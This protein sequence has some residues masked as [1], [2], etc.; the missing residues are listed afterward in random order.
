MAEPGI[1]QN[2]LQNYAL[3]D[4]SEGAAW[5]SSGILPS[6]IYNSSE[7]VK[8]DIR[9]YQMTKQA[10]EFNSSEAA[11]NRDFQQRMSNTSFQRAA[12]DLK[13]AGYS[14]LA[15]LG[16]G[17]ASSPSGSVASSSSPGSRG[18]GHDS[19]SG[20]IVGSL[21]AAFGSLLTKG[22]T[23]AIKAASVS[24][25]AAAAAGAASGSTSASAFKETLASK[26]ISDKDFS[27]L[28]DHLYDR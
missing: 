28:M 9:S 23:S 27:D 7:A 6:N 19:S 16:Q 24:T 1:V 25:S 14:P 22:V 10:Q 13:A 18:G 2:P 8:A 17:G 20:S 5:K 12:A 3:D 4:S 11:K 26:R 15:L 21:I